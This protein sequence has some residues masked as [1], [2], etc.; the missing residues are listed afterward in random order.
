MTNPENPEQR[1][2]AQQHSPEII[3]LLLFRHGETDWN[4][5]RRWQ[6]SNDIPLNQ[7]GRAQAQALAAVLQSFGPEIVLSSDLSRAHETAQLAS[8]DLSV[9]IVTSAALRECHFGVAEGLTREEITE[10]YGADAVERYLS[11]S[12]QELEFCFEGGESKAIH[13]QRVASYL[14]QQLLTL[15]HSRVAVST[16][17]GVL[18]RLLSIVQ[19]VPQQLPRIGNCAYF[20]I[21]FHR[22]PQQWHFVGGLL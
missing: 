4:R 10:R 1:A 19:G 18:W 2:R 7:T 13:L 6:G 3:E 9:P 12:P 20:R 22:L 8:A 15:P 16:H 17:G 14:T 11:V 5:A 21:D